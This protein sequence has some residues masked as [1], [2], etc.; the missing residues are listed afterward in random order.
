MG[1][2]GAATTYLG[3]EGVAK[4]GVIPNVVRCGADCYNV[5]SWAWSLKLNPSS[6]YK[7]KSE[8]D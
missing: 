8:A 5:L 4:N 2:G 7:K 6:N 1:C 3:R